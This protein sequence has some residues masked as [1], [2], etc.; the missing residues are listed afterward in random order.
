MIL[1]G[2]DIGDDCI[3]IDRGDWPEISRA[4]RRTIG[5]GIV[6]Q[7]RR[8]LA[9]R[10]ITVSLGNTTTGWSTLAT[11]DSLRALRDA[12]SVMSL[13][14]GTLGTYTVKF[15]AGDDSIEAIPVLGVLIDTDP[16]DLYDCT[17]R[18]MEV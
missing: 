18:L 12:D 11:V 15:T 7:P 1:S 8:K 13:D 9:G 3:W 5:G 16:T 10:P 2:I 17:L 4:E 6:F 14:M